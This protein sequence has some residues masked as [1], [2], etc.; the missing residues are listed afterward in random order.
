MN[1]DANDSTWN[2]GSMPAGGGILTIRHKK[3]GKGYFLGVRNLR[4]RAYDLHRL[5]SLGQHHNRLLQADWTAEPHAFE[6]VVV[7]HVRCPQML[8]VFKQIWIERNESSYNRKNAIPKKSC[9]GND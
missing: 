8:N 6:I 2:W 5:L 4:Q 9:H 1:I 3:T 7:E